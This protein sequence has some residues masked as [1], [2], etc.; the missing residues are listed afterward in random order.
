MTFKWNKI[1]YAPKD[2]TIVDLWHPEMGR[3]TD[4]QRR[5]ATNGRVFY[6]AA[7]SGPT[8]IIGATHFMIVGPPEGESNG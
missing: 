1:R 8:C 5:T 6:E 4:M 3:L 2:D 7:L